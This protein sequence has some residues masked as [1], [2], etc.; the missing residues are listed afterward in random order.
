MDKYK[1]LFSNTVIFA[2]GT[3][4]SKVLVFLLMPLYTWALSPD[5]YAVTDLIV[6]SGNLLLPLVSLGIVNS[7][8]RFGLDKSV[9]KSDVFTSG[10]ITVA[11]GF[12]GLIL[13][14]P[15]LSMIDI[16]SGNILLVYIFTLTSTL[17]SLC[18]QFVR[19]RGMVRLFAF[20]GVLSTI[21]T[22][23]FNVLF[24]VVFKFGVI[25]Y[26]MAIV[27]S[28]L[29]SSVFLFFVASLHRFVQIKTFNKK[30]WKE[31]LIYALPLIPN[32]ICWWITN[33]SDRF[34]VTY[35]LGHHMD[36]LYAVSYKLP[37]IIT[38]FS[39]IFMSAWQISA[40]TEENGRSKFFTQIFRSY[41][42]LIFMA[43]AAIIPFSKILVMLFAQP[44]YYDAWQF[45]PFLVMAT[46]FNCF[47]TFLGSVFAVEKKSILMFLTI[48]GGAALNVALNF[49]LIPLWG[50]NGAA[51]A[52][53][54]SYVLVFILRFIG[55]RRYI[56]IQIPLFQF[57]SNIVVLLGMALI[58]IFE[59]PG[60]IVFEALLL[61]ALL[62]LNLRDLLQTAMKLLKRK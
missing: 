30:I 56:K 27:C 14:S 1:K 26:V 5:E 53:F 38:L 60:W 35:M 29:L 41:S 4:S 58:M 51:F 13:L 3:F 46:V 25:G 32:T 18:S 33:V 15:L 7:I 40:I 17:R 49:L 20:D 34:I 28:D 50:V 36:G 42:S 43:G 23:L 9:R 44:S 24:L 45:I 19:A 37:T 54:A 59:I 6:Q 47:G 8:I 55:T 2:I 16:F 57:L 31:M 48:S 22:I 21:T 10:L 62:A 61:I 11:C 12:C 52:T 39:S